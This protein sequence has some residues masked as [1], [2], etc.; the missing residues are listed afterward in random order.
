MPIPIEKLDEAQRPLPVRILDFLARSPEQAHSLWEIRIGVE[1]IAAE[2]A[3]MLA[4][5]IRQD[6]REKVL[7]PY[8]Q[9]LAKLC[10]EGQVRAAKYQGIQYFAFVR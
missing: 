10:N 1:D 3:A 8:R 9:A 4:V 5:F 2:A 6:Q 7:E